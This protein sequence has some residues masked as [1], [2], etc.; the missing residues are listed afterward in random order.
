MVLCLLLHRYELSAVPYVI[1]CQMSA[2][3]RSLP[4]RL[5]LASIFELLHTGKPH[6]RTHYTRVKVLSESLQKETMHLEDFKYTQRVFPHTR[7][8]NSMTVFITMYLMFLPWK[9]GKVSVLFGIADPVPGTRRV[10]E[11]FYWAGFVRGLTLLKRGLLTVF[12]PYL[13]VS[14]CIN[15]SEFILRIC[16]VM[17]P[18]YVLIRIML[19]VVYIFKIFP[20]GFF[21]GGGWG[22][23]KHILK[24]FLSYGISSS[25]DYRCGILGL[26]A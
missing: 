18:S 15:R 13:Y 11:H 14:V 19:R 21:G 3:S 4:G 24:T 16:N 1:D 26:D 2:S 10:R 20:L 12:L 6:N 9:A 5:F 25:F 22:E 17:F 7:Q 23:V 8:I